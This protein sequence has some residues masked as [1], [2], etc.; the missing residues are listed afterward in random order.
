MIRTEA[1]RS[2]REGKAERIKER[3]AAARGMYQKPTWGQAAALVR[4]WQLTGLLIDWTHLRELILAAGS[5]SL[6]R[7]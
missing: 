5:T 3:V 6:S 7:G 1:N 2:S 4:D